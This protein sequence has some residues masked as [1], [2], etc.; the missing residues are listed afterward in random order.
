[1]TTIT[2]KIKAGVKTL[3]KEGA[4]KDRIE[5][6]LLFEGVAKKDAIAFLKEQGIIGRKSFRQWLY[7]RCESG[8]LSEKEFLSTLEATGSNN[9]KNHVG[10]Y[11]NERMAFNKIHAKYSEEQAELLKSD[12]LDQEALK[13]QG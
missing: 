8:V 7:S 11:N 3:I 5:G 2:T 1:M 6:Y 12:R 4:N 9:E 13:N 10:T